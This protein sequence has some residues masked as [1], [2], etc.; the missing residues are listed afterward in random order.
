MALEEKRVEYF[1]RQLLSL[2]A[3]QK[4]LWESEA[5]VIGAGGLGCGVLPAL[6]GAGFGRIIIVD[7]DVVEVSNLHRQTLY[8][9]S[10][11]GQSK[12]HAAAERL[13]DLCPFTKIVSIHE[14]FTEK[15]AEKLVPSCTIIFDCSD[16]VATRLLI[17][18][19]SS[20]F[21]KPVVSGSAL[22]NQG[23]LLVYSPGHDK[24]ATYRNLLG[25]KADT[26]E[27][28]AWE[29]WEGGTIENKALHLLLA[30]T[31]PFPQSC[32]DEGVIGPLPP[33]VGYMMALKG[34]YVVAN[35]GQVDHEYHLFHGT[36]WSQYVLTPKSQLGEELSTWRPDDY[37]HKCPAELVPE[38]PSKHTISWTDLIPKKVSLNCA[39]R[40]GFWM[41]GQYTILDVRPLEQKRIWLFADDGGVTLE[42]LM[43]RITDW[44]QQLETSPDTCMRKIALPIWC[45][46][47][48]IAV[49]CRR[50]NASAIVVCRLVYL[51]RAFAHELRRTGEDS[52]AESIRKFVRADIRNIT[53]GLVAL[54]HLKPD[55]L[56]I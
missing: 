42:I 54:K 15:L 38:L 44:A 46:R 17:S 26:R 56:F 21:R 5:L 20:I 19:A 2:G 14:R 24:Q 47:P 27:T 7:F 39:H 16:N 9:L 53:G 4:V 32:Q 33:M 31:R 29:D 55:V 28:L 49:Y 36:H 30:E 11:V 12:A 48:N 22:R 40:Y 10:L 8:G 23:Q 52:V 43:W 34:L 37:I 3:D 51:Q 41:Q 35:A 25:E 6:A 45:T 13:R 18:D 1:G 50:G